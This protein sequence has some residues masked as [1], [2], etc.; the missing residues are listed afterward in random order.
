MNINYGL[1]VAALSLVS[2]VVTASYGDSAPKWDIDKD[3]T[4]VGFT[5]KHFF[6]PIA[7][8]FM[9]VQGTLRFDPENLEGSAFDVTI[10]VASI[11]TRNA[12]R[13]KHLQS[14]DFFDA[15]KWPA[16]RFVSESIN[17]TGDNTYTV[18]GK[19]TI[20]DVTRDVE[21]PMELLGIGDVKMNLIGKT[22]VASLHIKHQLNRNDYGVGAGSWAAT[23][24]VGDQVN[25]D[26]LMELHR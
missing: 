20:R 7:G 17:K 4:T 24:V 22:T 5:V 13:D 18:Q 6:T 25:V 26:V 1:R 12:K 21:F 11:N 3:H 9:D 23:A 14:G 16:M 15:K 19:L 2:V 8:D 10:P